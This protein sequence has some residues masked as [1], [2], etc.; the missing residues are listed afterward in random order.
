MHMHFVNEKKNKGGATQPH[1]QKQ[2][3]PHLHD[4]VNAAA[5]VGAQEQPAK[6]RGRRAA[7]AVAVAVPIPVAVA[8]AVAVP[9]VAIPFPPQ[10]ICLASAS[11]DEGSLVVSEAAVNITSA[12]ASRHEIALAPPSVSSPT[13]STIT[14][15]SA[16]PIVVTSFRSVATLSPNASILCTASGTSHWDFTAGGV[17]SGSSIRRK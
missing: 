15:T 6:Q 3:Q 10:V 14:N 12:L 13:S 2:E 7:S 8:V 5:A 4:N 11:T 16:L 17:G 1:A 9:V